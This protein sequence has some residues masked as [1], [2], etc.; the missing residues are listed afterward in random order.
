LVDGHGNFGSIDGDSPAAMRY[1]EIRLQKL[2]G[3]LLED[4]ECQTVDFVPNFDN[5]EHEPTVLPAR[6][7]NVL[8]NGSSGIAVGMATNIPPHNLAEVIDGTIT[9]IDNPEASLMDIMEHI[10]GPDFPTAGFIN[11][12]DG[13]LSAYKTGRG[14]IQLSSKIDIEENKSK[15]VIVVSEL[16]FQVNK[17]K[18]LTHIGQLVRD[19]KIEGIHTLRDESDRHGMRIAIEV[20]RGENAE[21]LKNNLL[22]QT[23]LQ[24]SFGI[25][26]VCLDHGVPK[27]MPLLDILKAFVAHRQEVVTRRTVFLLAKARSKA[28]VLE[29]LAVA[30]SHLDEVIELVKK[31]PNPGEAKSKLLAKGWKIDESQSV[32]SYLKLT[33]PDDLDHLFGLREGKYYFSPQQAQAILDLRLHR[34]TGLERDKIINDHAECVEKIKDF[35]DILSHFERLMS[36]IKEE[37][38]EIK[39]QFNDERKSVIIADYHELSNEDLIPKQEVV[40][41]ITKEGYAK[42]QPTENYQAQRRGGR[43]KSSGNFKEE[44]IIRFLRTASSHDT[45]LCFTNKGRV[46][47]LKVYQ[48]P[49]SSRASRGK[50]LVNYLKFTSDEFLSALLPLKTLDD[51]TAIIM[52]TEKGVIK[53]TA[54][55]AFSR[56]RSTGMNAINLDEQD[57]LISA[58]IVSPNDQIMLFTNHGKVNRFDNND[59]R[60]IGRNAR[61]VRGIKLGVDH[62][63]ISMIVV[64]GDEEILTVSDK[65]F[66]KKTKLQYFRQT[67]RGGSGV[68]AMRTTDKVG[69]VIGALPVAP[70]DELLLLTNGGTMIRILSK[71]VSLIKRQ[72]Q[73]VKLINLSSEER[74]VAVQ[75]IQRIEG[76][77]DLDEDIDETDE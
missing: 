44:D 22:K 14:K 13:I 40:V 5:T 50:P 17:A 6:F 65:G 71:D 42:A 41:T 54:L 12:T 24:T 8:V 73:G 51:D 19:K 64:S 32:F 59:L 62:K 29:G 1:T 47:W 31:A 28:H 33:R 49:I 48:L 7:P 66:G 39:N 45:M 68:I 53:K 38:L 35:I 43:G 56:P 3:K 9:L 70:E 34:L 60:S 69:L 25:N 55:S 52:A 16:P 30:I 77:D 26:V 57:R 21:V 74:L 2:S 10:K 4:I 61:G 72:T 27:C 76:F 23:M 11:G 20:K 18:L 36:V 46:F 75:S 15:D 37:L 58:E 63:V 67:M